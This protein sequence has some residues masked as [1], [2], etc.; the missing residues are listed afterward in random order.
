[1]ALGCWVLELFGGLEFWGLG[2][3]VFLGFWATVL[4]LGVGNFGFRVLALGGLE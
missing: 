1:M 3:W 4:G 2:L